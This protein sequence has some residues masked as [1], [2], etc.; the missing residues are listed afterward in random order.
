MDYKAIIQQNYKDIE[1]IDAQTKA[2]KQLNK[3]LKEIKK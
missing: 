1:K 3:E 2:L